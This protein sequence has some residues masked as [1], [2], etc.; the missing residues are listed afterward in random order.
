MS[1]CVFTWVEQQPV[2]GRHYACRPA[3]VS[4][5]IRVVGRGTRPYHLYCWPPRFPTILRLR[6]AYLPLLLPLPLPLMPLEPWL[7][8]PLKLP[9][10]LPSLRLPF[11]LPLSPFEPWLLLPLMLPFALPLLLPLS[12]FEAP[13]LLPLTLPFL[14]P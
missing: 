2:V 4:A 14:E 13:F 5:S 8:L 9:F 11:T 3:L 10:A 1:R 12:P 7:R 6:R